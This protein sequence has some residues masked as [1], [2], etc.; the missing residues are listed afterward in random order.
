MIREQLEAAQ[1]VK[2]IMHEENVNLQERLVQAEQEVQE[3][4]K[5]QLLTKR[6]SRQRAAL[7]VDTKF[8][9]CVVCLDRAPTVVCMPCKHLALCNQCCDEELQCCPICRC[10][11]R[12]KIDVFLP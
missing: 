7:D 1:T 6:P 8:A 12:D 3:L 2:D 4:Q 9:S 11:V 5:L 10:D